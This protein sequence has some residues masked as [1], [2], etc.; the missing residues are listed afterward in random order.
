MFQI[1]TEQGGQKNP[2]GDLEWGLPVSTLSTWNLE[3]RQQVD[4]IGCILTIYSHAWS[5]NLL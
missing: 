4:A 3:Q 1:P 2:Y 5:S